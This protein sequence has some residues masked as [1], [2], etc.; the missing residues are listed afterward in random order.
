[1]HVLVLPRVSQRGRL[2]LVERA[3]KSRDDSRL[4]RQDCL[5]PHSFFARMGDCTVEDTKT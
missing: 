3:K 5:M 4:C 2:S 1:M